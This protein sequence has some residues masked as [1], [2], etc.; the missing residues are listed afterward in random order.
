M[1]FLSLEYW[2]EFLRQG[3]GTAY[4]HFGTP[5]FVLLVGTGLYCC[6]RFLSLRR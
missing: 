4:Y 5:F 1:E 6:W 2:A 3:Y